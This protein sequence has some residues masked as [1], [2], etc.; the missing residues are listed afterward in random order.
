MGNYNHGN[1][2]LHMRIPKP[3]GKSGQPKPVDTAH[4]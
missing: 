4:V 3:I 2:L 1:Y